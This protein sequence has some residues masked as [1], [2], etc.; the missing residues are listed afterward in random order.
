MKIKETMLINRPANES[1]NK[2]TMV[3]G[4]VSRKY[5]YHKS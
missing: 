5:I 1:W 3:P 2:E 4:V